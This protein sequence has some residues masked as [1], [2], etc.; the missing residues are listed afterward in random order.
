MFDYAAKIKS[1]EIKLQ[2]L[3]KVQIIC[4]KLQRHQWNEGVSLSCC[5]VFLLRQYAD[6]TAFTV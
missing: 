5:L 1:A 4:F 6:L 3:L 2:G